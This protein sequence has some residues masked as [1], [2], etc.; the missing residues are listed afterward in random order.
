MLE[1][2]FPQK[3]PKLTRRQVKGMVHSVSK[4]LCRYDV[5]AGRE[6]GCSV[7]HMSS[8]AFARI[9]VLLFFFFAAVA[10]YFCALRLE[11][12]FGSPLGPLLSHNSMYRKEN[13]P[14]KIQSWNPIPMRYGLRD[15]DS[16]VAGSSNRETTI[17]SHEHDVIKRHYVCWRQRCGNKARAASVTTH[18]GIKTSAVTS[19]ECF[20]P[21]W[22][23]LLLFL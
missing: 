2:P 6:I 22:F 13:P 14:Q 16:M 1:S 7:M 23:F 15:T 20:L 17:Y 4:S 11:P 10:L 21:Y 12:I 19:S 9:P 5:S 3:A 18:E 8:S